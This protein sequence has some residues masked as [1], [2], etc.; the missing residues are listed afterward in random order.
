MH[1]YVRMLWGKLVIQQTRNYEEE[2]A[3]L[4]H[5][6]N[7]YCLDGRNPNSYAGILGVSA[8]TT[9]LGWSKMNFVPV[10]KIFFTKSFSKSIYHCTKVATQIFSNFH[11]NRKSLTPKSVFCNRK[12]NFPRKHSPDNKMPCCFSVKSQ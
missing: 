10:M 8:S 5:L 2:F 11:S 7:K 6:N 1:N 12:K 9:D 3:V 4:E